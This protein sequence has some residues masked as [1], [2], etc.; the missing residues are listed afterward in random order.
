MST[1]NHL[2]TCFGLLTELSHGAKVDILES[3]GD[4]DPES[5][6]VNFLLRL[7]CFL[8]HSSGQQAECVRYG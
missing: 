8:S 7:L 2:E 5:K 3:V 1:S 4:M 6:G